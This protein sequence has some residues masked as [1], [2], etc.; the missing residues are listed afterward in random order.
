[1]TDLAEK[2]AREHA[3]VTEKV[4]EGQA[5]ELYRS[6]ACGAIPA[7]WHARARHLIDTTE[8]AVREQVAREIEARECHDVCGSEWKRGL[9]EA[10]HIARGGAS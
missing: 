9:R 4:V 5:V 10:A 3:L 1:M 6:C 8:A 7:S 2:I